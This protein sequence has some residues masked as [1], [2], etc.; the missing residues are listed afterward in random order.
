M[1][2]LRTITK[3]IIFYCQWGKYTENKISL[4][5]TTEKKIPPATTENRHQR[6]IVR[7]ICWNKCLPNCG[8]MC[9]P[10]TTTLNCSLTATWILSLFH[11]SVP[12]N[13]Y[14]RTTSNDIELFFITLQTT[15]YVQTDQQLSLLLART[16]THTAHAVCVIRI[17]TSHR[18][19]ETHLPFSK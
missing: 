3:R 18:G 10:F 9:N 6:L 11:C 1:S 12:D 8:T 14:V 13:G 2:K 7:N 17:S 16:S 4:R 5:L 19:Y 15:K